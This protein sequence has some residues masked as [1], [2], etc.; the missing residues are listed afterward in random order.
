[1]PL[2]AR[3]AV[4]VAICLAL[5]FHLAAIT[6]ANLPAST[7]L[8]SGLYAPFAWYLTP[9]GLW[10]TWDMFTTIPHFLE[11][12]GSLVAIDEQGVAKRYGPLLPGFTPFV[13]STRI[14][15][16]FMRLAFSNDIYPT[17]S[18]RYRGAVCRALLAQ[19]NGAPTQVG[20]ELRALELR[21]L[22]DIRKDGRIG[23]PRTYSFGP[24]PCTP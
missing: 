21:A 14:Q 17:Y 13:E 6:A 16:S 8:G 5:V 18:T 11:L 23:Q 2:L 24:T 12:D 22:T 3:R 20:F 10:Q 15:G 9:T 7:A 1:M 4:R 19:R